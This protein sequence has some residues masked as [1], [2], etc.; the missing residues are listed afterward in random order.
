MDLNS[1][2]TMTLEGH[3]SP[4]RAVRFVDVPSANAPII[5]SGS[6]DKT[7]RYWDMRQQQSIG[8]LHLPE[9]VYGMDTGGSLL[10]IAT[11][12]PKVH[13]VN[14]HDNPL[15]LWRSDKSPLK[16]QLSAASVTPDGTRW[17]VGGIE[18]R[19]AAQSVNQKDK[20]KAVDI[21]FKCHRETIE[22]G[23]ADV[24]AV[25]DVAFSP[26]HND[27]LATAGS[28]GTY[29]IWDVK[30]RT[31][32]RSFPKVEAPVTAV[33][34]T[35][36]GRGLAYAT[37]YDWSKGYQYSKAGAETKITLRRFPAALKTP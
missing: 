13:L 20:K 5:A 17:A 7:V 16:R 23:H 30:S 35:R 22:E 15:E 1:S 12:E 8:V 24:Y 2:Q 26:A 34:F 14:L 32:L 6:W 3:T 11:A 28:D 18:G 19:A 21:S 37:G 9:R 33:S 31:R 27:V 10:V 36:D 4:V 29:C 25:N